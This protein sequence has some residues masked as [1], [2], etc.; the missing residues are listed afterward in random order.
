MI[1]VKRTPC[2][3]KQAC[4]LGI[5]S[6]DVDGR[7]DIPEA[8]QTV[9]SLNVRYYVDRQVYHDCRALLLTIQSL[10]VGFLRVQSHSPKQAAYVSRRE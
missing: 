5:E 10:W 4:T 9:S 7:Q 8:A 1:R 6:M 3:M 2:C